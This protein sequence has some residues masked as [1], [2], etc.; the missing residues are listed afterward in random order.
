MSTIA[1]LKRAEFTGSN[2]CWPCT[3]LNVALL[4]LVV[5][6]LAPFRPIPAAAAAVVGT[7]VIWLRG[8]LVP[9]TPRFAPKLAARLP[10]DVF[11]HSPRADSLDDVRDGAADGE[12]VLEALVEAGVVTVD[13]TSSG[14]ETVS[15]TRGEPAC[16]HSRTRR[17]RSSRRHSRTSRASMPPA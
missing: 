13:A 17:T 6:V 9:Y 3:A 14:S 5:G 15:L 8:Y 7:A 16:R 11:D 2:R 12:A 10:G 1:G 4:A